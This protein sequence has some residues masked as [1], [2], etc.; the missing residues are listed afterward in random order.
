[1][2]LGLQGQWED[3]GSLEDWEEERRNGPLGEKH[4][5]RYH[6]HCFLCSDSCDLRSRQFARL[7]KPILPCTMGEHLDTFGAS[8]GLG[9]AGSEEAAVTL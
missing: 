8:L 5:A 4:W 6:F 2:V 1:M 7:D 3:L 9:A